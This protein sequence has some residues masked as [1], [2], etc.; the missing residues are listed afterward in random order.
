MRNQ[1]LP[2]A[3]LIFAI[4]VFISCRKERIPENTG[5][6]SRTETK[7]SSGSS[8]QSAESYQEGHSSGDCGNHG[9]SGSSGNG[10]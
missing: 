8:G 7:S 1:I 3:V 2:A 10:D 9:G 4:T 6:Q 5:T